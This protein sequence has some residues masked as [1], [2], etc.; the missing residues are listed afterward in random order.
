[1]RGFEQYYQ[2]VKIWSKQPKVQISGLIS[3]TYFTIAFFLRFAILPTFET[4]GSL[5]KEIKDYQTI[6]GKL[7]NK[8]YNLEMA[9]ANY[10]LAIN[11]LESVDRVLPQT[12]EAER[13]AWQIQWVAQ[14]EG[15]KIVSGSFG[16]FNLISPKISTDLNKLETSLSIS[17]SYQQIKAFLQKLTNIDRLLTIEEISFNKQ[18][19]QGEGKLTVS[20]KLKGFYWPK[21][22]LND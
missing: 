21:K 8:I 13:L 19:F 22:E 11:D 18:D 1:M 4:I 2:R 7:T 3:L 5:S 12:A 10:S 9:E 16:E 6:I 15:V 20:L 17:G 14:Q